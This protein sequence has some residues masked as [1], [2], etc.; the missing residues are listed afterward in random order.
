MITVDSPYA[1]APAAA[2]VPLP[3]PHQL[4]HKNPRFPVERMRDLI[5]NLLDAIAC[6]KCTTDKKII[7]NLFLSMSDEETDDNFFDACRTIYVYVYYPSN[8]VDSSPCP[9][10][11]EELQE[12]CNLFRKAYPQSPLSVL[13]SYVSS[14]P[15]TWRGIDELEREFEEEKLA[16]SNEVCRFIY[17]NSKELDSS[18]NIKGLASDRAERLRQMQE[19]ALMR[20][21]FILDLYH[22]AQQARENYLAGAIGFGTGV[23]VS[24]LTGPG[25]VLGGAITAGS[26][27]TAVKTKTYLR[28][29]LTRSPPEG[30]TFIELSP[31]VSF[32]FNDRSSG[33]RRWNPVNAVRQASP[34]N[35]YGYIRIFFT[36]EKEKGAMHDCEFDQRNKE[37]IAGLAW[38]ELHAH[39]QAAL[40]EN[41]LTYAKLQTII[42]AMQTA[43]LPPCGDWPARKL[44]EPHTEVFLLSLLPWHLAAK[45]NEIRKDLEKKM[46]ERGLLPSVAFAFPEN[47]QRS[48]PWK[49][50]PLPT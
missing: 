29:I 18:S 26:T 45:Q 31:N 5:H 35:T 14:D 36:D 42:Q 21:Q 25:I 24:L 12:I 22:R 43:T 41:T 38:G 33:L 19:I 39:M 23:A 15:F 7:F 17:L 46:T 44:L 4:S 13:L 40:E 9:S 50:T 37:L 1:T 34:S 16:S 20:L 11:R 10:E 6:P 30:L 32:A 47:S 3:P 8:I 48:S 28:G 27:V 49:A 2:L